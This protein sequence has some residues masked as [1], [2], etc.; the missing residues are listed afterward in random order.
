[1]A[2][3]FGRKQARQA[4]DAHERATTSEWLEAV[5]TATGDAGLIQ[6]LRHG[7]V[8]V[9]TREASTHAA[10]THEASTHEAPTLVSSGAV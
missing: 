2:R 6:P 1:M 4:A 10:P 7:P 5:I 3:L 8:V 9:S